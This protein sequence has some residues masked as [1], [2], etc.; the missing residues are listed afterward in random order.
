ME[1]LKAIAMT[2][3]NHNLDSQKRAIKII[4]RRSISLLSTAL[5]SFPIPSASH[6][7]WIRIVSAPASKMAS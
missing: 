2:T 4:K 7:I 3:P 1:L 5:A 6:P